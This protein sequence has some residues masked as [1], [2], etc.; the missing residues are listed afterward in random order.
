VLHVARVARL[1][2]SYYLDDLGD[3]L[4]RVAPLHRGA[5]AGRW[6]GGG[7]SGLGLTGALDGQALRV[8]LDG[9]NP[10]TGRPLVSVQRR[11]VA[12][13]DLTF[14]AP[15]SV[16]L[17]LA[18]SESESANQ[19]LAG[20]RAAVHAAVGHLERR[21]LSVRRGTRDD[22]G[23]IPAGGIVGAS[24]THALSRAGDPHLHTHVLVA[25]L[26]H[27]ADGRWSAVDSRGL[28]AHARAAGAL[29]DAHLRAELTERVGLGW[30]WHETRGWDIDGSEP[31]LLAAFSGRAA[32]I[33]QDLGG[34]G[35][36]S[37]RARRVAWAATREPKDPSRSSADLGADWARRAA[38]APRWRLERRKNP[39]SRSD[40]IDEYRF[41]AAIAGC[42]PSGVSRRDVVAAWSGALANGVR[43]DELERSVDH[44][45]P[46]H[47]GVVGVGEPKRAPG[48]FV[49]ANHLLNVLGARPAVAEGQPVWRR[50]AA[51]I[52]HYR[53]RWGVD[54]GGHPLRAD[55]EHLSGLT[56]LQLAD[57]LELARTL[58]EALIRLGRGTRSSLERE[59]L[60]F[61]RR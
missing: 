56:H 60:A 28:F 41:A 33:R 55:R 34:R 46:A 3:E 31:L 57:H 30:S 48:H 61:E 16:S 32:E 26:A 13:F 27:G 14:S 53:T 10:R 42:P 59:G 15:K 12:G 52:D 37:L 51:A 43:A 39:G 19:V 2:A 11:S 21:A 44:W 4:R 58:D 23:P 54:G 45:A 50:A 1:G 20:H 18:L 29:Y 9:A 38:I 6:I 35:T 47:D 22:R 7:T 5:D 40:Q 24:F 25:N 17:L 36:R 8:L 49:P